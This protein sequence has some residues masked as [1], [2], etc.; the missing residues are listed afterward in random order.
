MNL[1]HRRMWPM[2]ALTGFLILAFVSCGHAGGGVDPQLVGTWQLK[3]TSPAIYWEIRANGTYTVSGPGAAAGHSGSFR[4]S[5]GKW[6]LRSTTWG[7]DGGTYQLP[8]ANTFLGIGKLGAGTWVRTSPVKS[9][10]KEKPA[11]SA[12]PA[13]SASRELKLATQTD[14]GKALPKDIPELTAA[15]TKRARQWK[16]DAAAVS[17]EF[18][19]VNA[20]NLKGPEVRYSFISPS[21]GTGLMLTVTEGGVS[22]HEFQQKVNWGDNPLPPVF[23]D[24]PAAVVSARR[25]GMKGPINSASLRIYDAHGVTALAWMVSASSGGRTVD[26]ATG[27]IIERD[28]TGYIDDYNE[29]WDKAARALR[30]M[31]RGRGHGGHGGSPMFD[32]GSSS[33]SG[34]EGGGYEGMTPEEYQQSVAEDN[35]YWNGSSED[36]ERVKSGECTWSDSSNYGC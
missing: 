1:I 21:D 22:T 32:G 20:P 11:S 36:Y 4:A 10:G 24:L 2:S 13:R 14:S 3:G 17:V 7:E 8:D 35:A 15:A 19:E 26:G 30:A 33:G 5:G 9:A 6:S 29:Q 34:P 31:L 28:V 25:N 12:K 18:R 23:V 16:K 27:D